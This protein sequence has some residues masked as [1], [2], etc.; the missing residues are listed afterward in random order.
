MV[1][2]PISEV[3]PSFQQIIEAFIIVYI[4]LMVIGEL[5]AGTIFQHFF[6]AARALFVILYLIFQLKGGIVGITYQNVNLI[7]DLRL[8]MTIAILLSLLGIAKSVFQAI[9]FMNEKAEVAYF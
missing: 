7:A 2:T 1:M 4:I 5:S 6:N 9:N 3:V 8:F